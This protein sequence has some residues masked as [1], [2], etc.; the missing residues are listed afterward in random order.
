MYLLQSGTDRMRVC[1]MQPLADVLM[2]VERGYRMESPEG[3]P[4][5]VYSMMKEAWDTN[6]TARPTFASI[7]ARL[8]ALR[9]P[10]PSTAGPTAF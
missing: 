6:A 9:S 2:H 1:A 5:E 7:A 10:P 4:R 8:A 3:C